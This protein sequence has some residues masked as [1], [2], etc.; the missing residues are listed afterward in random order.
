MPATEFPGVA[1]TRCGL[2]TAA[3]AITLACLACGDRSPTSL[4]PPS[5]LHSTRA[6]N[7]PDQDEDLA[8]LA[9]RIPG[10]AG[11]FLRG[12]TVV[13]RLKTEQVAE[14]A[15]T[16]LR[17]ALSVELPT[18]RFRN[19]NDLLRERV[20]AVEGSRFDARE[21][22]DF[23]LIAREVAFAHGAQRLDI[24]ETTGTLRVSIPPGID[25]ARLRNQ[26]LQ[27]GIAPS[28]LVIRY[29]EP[30][31]RRTDLNDRLRPV[32]GAV[33]TI[34]YGQSLPCTVTLNAVTSEGWGFITAAHCTSEYGAVHGDEF[35]Q[36]T[37]AGGNLIGYEAVDPA[38]L[39]P[40]TTY[41]PAW[42]NYGCRSSDAA[43]LW[44][45]SSSLPDSLTIART[46]APNGSTTISSTHPRFLVS[47]G[48]L[49]F[50]YDGM[51]V[52]KVG[53]ATGWT[54]GEVTETCEDMYLGGIITF[55]A[56]VTDLEND[57]GDSG[58][59]FFT[60][61]GSS[62]YVE[63]VGLLFSGSEYTAEY[64]PWVLVWFEITQDL[65]D[66]IEIAY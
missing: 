51:D 36:P 23:K 2:A 21:L 18:T 12:D 39:S 56:A 35:Y 32:P 57:D 47:G 14:S 22:W 42:V 50:P 58:A 44:Y 28:A 41:C 25:S 46:N 65:G 1:A 9:D 15:S 53:I 24:D 61:D 10:F 60:W 7:A 17:Q 37:E 45:S 19:I 64:S 63:V 33:S 62:A 5:T 27:A 49:D 26:L 34:G 43:F 59:P 55:C 20:S 30:S 13:L 52:Y 31:S 38:L 40:G 8:L 11:F 16:R 29:H 54:A 3:L 48:S 4:S 66:D 6:A